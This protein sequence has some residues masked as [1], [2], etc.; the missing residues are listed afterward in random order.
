MQSPTAQQYLQNFIAQ[1]LPES[2]VGVFDGATDDP[3]FAV[4]LTY[5]PS[6]EMV[7]PLG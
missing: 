2:G 7:R 4:D 6:P 3:H 5:R 1:R